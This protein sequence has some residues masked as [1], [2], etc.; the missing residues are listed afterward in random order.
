[1]SVALDAGTL[2]AEL[3][4]ALSRADAGRLVSATL[5][6]DRDLDPVAIAAGSRL[7]SDR[8]FSW[9]EPDRGAPVPAG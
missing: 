8:W 7:A 4:R 5:E 6:V 2:L 1:V 9:E 3:E